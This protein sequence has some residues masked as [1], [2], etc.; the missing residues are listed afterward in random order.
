M[1]V[2]SSPAALTICEYPHEHRQPLAAAQLP[3]FCT[4]SASSLT[5]RLPHCRCKS[6][7]N[8]TS[9]SLL[10][11][12]CRNHDRDCRAQPNRLLRHHPRR[13]ASTHVTQI[14]ALPLTPL[15][16]LRVSLGLT[17]SRANA[18]NPTMVTD[19]SEQGRSW[20]GSRWSCSEM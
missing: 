17:H 15:H 18:R 2:E 20:G 13:Y 5:A 9:S 12:H 3:C 10:A 16:L 4:C 19:I 14:V 8:V 6:L 11:L 1:R 7:S